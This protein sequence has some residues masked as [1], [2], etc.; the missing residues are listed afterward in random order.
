METPGQTTV[1]ELFVA[2]VEGFLDRTGTPPGVFGRE[3]MG[4]PGFVR[5]LRGGR[6][7][8]LRTV[9]RIV[10]FIDA[11]SPD[12]GGDFAFPGPDRLRDRLSRAWSG[13]W[14]ESEPDDAVPVRILRLS[15]V[16]DRTGLSR[17]TL[18]ELMEDGSFPRPVRLGAR[19][20]GWIEAEVDEWIRR[21]VDESRGGTGRPGSPA[22]S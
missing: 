12:E 11:R 17:S 1:T 19:A 6:S 14:V 21:R 8:T 2:K 18:Y 13:R 16:L 20:V 3:A 9:D 22:G 7:P 15:M 10:A 4:D 5:R